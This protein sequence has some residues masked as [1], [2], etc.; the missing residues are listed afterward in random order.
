MARSDHAQVPC[1]EFKVP[2]LG[3]PQS[4]VRQE[5]DCCHKDFPLTELELTGVQVLCPRCRAGGDEIARLSPVKP[6]V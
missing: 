4:A 5:C 1:G 2:L 3:I 6:G